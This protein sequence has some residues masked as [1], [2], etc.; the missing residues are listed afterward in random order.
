M[1]FFKFNEDD[2]FVNTIEAYPQ[3]K[4]YIQSG[5]IYIDDVPHLAGAN[6]DNI[7]GVPKGFVSLFEYNIDRKSTDLIYPFVYKNSA[8]DSW[9]TV[10]T[11]SFHAKNQYGDILT[12]SYLLSSS[13]SRYYYPTTTTGSSRQRIFSLE[14]L[15]DQN[16]YLSP[17]YKYNSFYENKNTQEICLLSIPSILYGSS[18]KK[19]SLSLKYYI[20]GTLMGELSDYRKNGELVQVGPAGSTGSGSVAGVVIYDRGFVAL[21]GSWD[22]NEDSIAYD[23]TGSSKW[24]HFGFGVPN[25]ETGSNG[26][27][28]SNTTLSASFLMEYSGTTRIQTMTMLA[29]A[30]YGELNHSNNPTFASSSNSL[31]F[32]SGAYQIKETPKTIKN[33]VHST[34]LDQKPKF[35]KVVYISKVGLYDKDKNLI[36]IAKVATPVKKTI[37]NQY[38][39]KIKLDI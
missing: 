31:T 38:T 6:T 23:V 30:K 27:A 8:Q 9:K 1:T 10:G 34:F 3:Y 29:H 20:T 37:D 24:T 7:T 21:T 32:V 28:I 25:R 12:S 16:T 22:L 4:Y 11:G 13:I 35:D 18:I 39:F 26:V 14:P 19:G 5:T 33:I 36:G 17:H 2:L 15:F